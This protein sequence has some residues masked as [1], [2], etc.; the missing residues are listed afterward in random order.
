MG[1]GVDG[2]LFGVENGVFDNE[3]GEGDEDDEEVVGKDT[4][5]FF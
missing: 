1:V 2:T 3:D 4:V 5:T